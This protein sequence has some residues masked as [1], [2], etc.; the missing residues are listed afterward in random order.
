MIPENREWFRL[1]GASPSVLKTLQSAAGGTL[2][3]VY[4][5][6]LAFSNGGEGPFGAQPGWLVLSSAEEA[7]RTWSDEVYAKFFP[8]YFVFG[9]NG[10]GEAFAF[11]LNLRGGMGERIVHFDMTNTDLPNSVIEL[12]R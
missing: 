4:L 7:A 12:A 1:D 6:L 3:Q 2:P 9:S 5:D 8:G 10:A 11:D